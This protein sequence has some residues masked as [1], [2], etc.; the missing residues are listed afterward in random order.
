MSPLLVLPEVQPQA[1]V[2]AALERQAVMV[3]SVRSLQP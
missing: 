3:L 1:L 2:L